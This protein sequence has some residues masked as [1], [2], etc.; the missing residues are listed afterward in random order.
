ME[1]KEIET[2]YYEIV[3]KQ[4]IAATKREAYKSI[5]RS[6]GVPLYG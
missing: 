4:S 6:A 3:K 2:I 1:V 5:L